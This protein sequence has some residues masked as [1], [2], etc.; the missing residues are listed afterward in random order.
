MRSK[1]DERLT[2]DH[3]ELS[4]LLGELMAALDSDDI[5]R[6]HAVMDLFWARLA[7]HI[8]A[9]HLHLFPAIT[10]V[11]S[12]KLN[13]CG[14]DIPQPG[15]VQ[16]TIEELRE[17]HDFFMRELARAVTIMRSLL[18]SPGGRVATRLAD[19]RTRITAV[20]ARLAKHN[21]IEENGIYLWTRC[22]LNEAEQAALVAGVRKELENMPPRF[23]AEALPQK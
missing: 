3:A 13:E 19:V 10:H 20:Q 6:S 18:A 4:D 11:A 8:R 22:L 2:H 16:T 7:I 14:S 1:D 9:E 5:A 15:E 21:E 12:R 17:D 23:T